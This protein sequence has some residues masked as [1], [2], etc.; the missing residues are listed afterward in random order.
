MEGRFTAN[1]GMDK[2]TTNEMHNPLCFKIKDYKS[3]VIKFSRNR[4]MRNLRKGAR[5]MSEMS[6]YTLIKY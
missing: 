3:M 4:K 2:P 5:K 6:I 1:T